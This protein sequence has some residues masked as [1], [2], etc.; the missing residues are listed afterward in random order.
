MDNIQ[1]V[2]DEM[3]DE[4]TGTCTKDHVILGDEYI[5]EGRMA[6]EFWEQNELEIARIIDDAIFKCER[7]GWWWENSEMSEE[8]MICNQC[9]D[10][11][12]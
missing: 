5:E 9:Y 2:A 10:E 8:D 4:L 6:A 3:I 7:C 1:A 11:D 12:E